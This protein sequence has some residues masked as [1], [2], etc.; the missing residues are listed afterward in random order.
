MV[1]PRK[2]AGAATA[3]KEP[4]ENAMLLLS[5]TPGGLQCLLP[6]AVP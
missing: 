1:L 5:K 2:N 6:K 3:N 4:E